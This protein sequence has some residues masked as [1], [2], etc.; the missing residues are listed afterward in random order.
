MEILNTCM[1]IYYMWFHAW[2]WIIELLPGFHMHGQYNSKESLN[3]HKEQL[4]VLK[5]KYYTD[6]AYL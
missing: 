6:S 5:T 3:G 2:F 1:M 4:L